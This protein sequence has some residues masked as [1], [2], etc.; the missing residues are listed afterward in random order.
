MTKRSKR[1]WD[2]LVEQRKRLSLQG[3][4]P[5]WARWVGRWREKSTRQASSNRDSYELLLRVGRWLAHTH[6]DIVSPEQWTRELAV[7]YVAAVER[8]CVGDWASDVKYMRNVGKPLRPA[9][10]AGYIS[11]VRVFFLNCET[12]GWLQRRF[13]PA[14]YLRTP[15]S[16]RAQLAPE[17]GKRLIDP[18]VWARLVWA[19]LNLIETDLETQSPWSAHPF[20]MVKAIA[21]TWLFCGL[22][23]NEL[24]RLRVGC[25]RKLPAD[26]NTHDS[27]CYL[28]VPASKSQSVFT[29]SVDRVVG[30]AIWAWEAVRPNWPSAVDTY[31]GEVVDFLFSYRGGPLGRY[32]LNGSL[33]PLLCRKANIP[34][35]D[36]KGPITSHRA[37]ATIASMLANA[38][39]PLSLLALK[40]WLGH[41]T[42]NATLH[43]MQDDAAA[44]TKAYTDAG[45]FGRNIRLVE[46]LV[47]QEAIESGATAS[48]EPWKYYDLGHGF[49]TYDFFDQCPHRMAC[50]RCSFYRPKEGTLEQLEEARG[51]LQRLLQQIPLTEAE[52]AAV[53]DG[54]KAVERLYSLLAA[55]PAPDGK[56]G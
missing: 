35:T 39:E 17:P 5:E 20:L 44:L 31:T 38:D 56:T 24:R 25:A 45:Y 37:R 12:W 1:S 41:A 40:E 36:S 8:W 51:N 4:A 47:D 3:V 33:I 46:V 19:G 42:L 11:T 18:D 43:Y 34:E 54:Q 16:Q 26:V 7:E 48:G 15:R 50:A 6:P 2:E 29:K 49:C 14:R 32:Y 52:A 55:E 23:N 30:E 21:L 28:E 27:V 13:D 9:T 53:E 22:R 10:K